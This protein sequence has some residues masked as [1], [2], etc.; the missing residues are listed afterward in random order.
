MLWRD[1]RIC[2]YFKLFKIDKLV[3]KFYWYDRKKFKDNF[4]EKLGLI[5]LKN[6]I[7]KRKYLEK[8][9]FKWYR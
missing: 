6:V 8:V 9:L 4:D 5:N 7:K 2:G 3:K 1:F